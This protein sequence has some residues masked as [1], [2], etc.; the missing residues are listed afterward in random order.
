MRRVQWIVSA[1][2][3][4][5]LFL[6]NPAGAR[7]VS[8]EDAQF[9]AANFTVAPQSGPIPLTVH[10]TDTSTGLVDHWEWDFGDHTTGSVEKNPSHVYEKVG[11]YTVILRVSG[12]YG[13]DSINRAVFTSYPIDSSRVRWSAHEVTQLCN[14]AVDSDGTVYVA[15]YDKELKALL[16]GG[17]EKWR[18]RSD[19]P[20]SPGSVPAVGTDTVYID[21]RMHFFAV[22]KADGTLKWQ[23]EH[24]FNAAASANTGAAIGPDG[25]VYLNSG[26]YLYALNPDGS[27]KWARNG[28]VFSIPIVDAYGTVYVS[29][30]CYKFSAFGTDGLPI[31]SLNVSNPSTA[32]PAMTGRHIIIPTPDRL[33]AL[34]H[35]G[36]VAWKTTQ[37]NST[38]AVVGNGVIYCGRADA[39]TAV[40]PEDGTVKWTYLRDGDFT[41][42]IGSLSVGI[43]GTLY[44]VFQDNNKWMAVHAI[45]PDGTRRWIN[46]MKGT[47]KVSPVLADGALYLIADGGLV[48]MNVESTAVA[49]TDWPCLRGNIAHTG[50]LEASP[51]DAALGADA[52]SGKYP[53]TVHFSDISSGTVSDWLWS[54]GDGETS[55]D[56]NPIHTYS[57]TGTFPVSLQVS[58]PAGT[59]QVTEPGFITVTPGLAV[60]APAAG[61]TWNGGSTHNINWNSAGI[62][63]PV[64][65]E[66]LQGVSAKTLFES[67]PNT[68]RQSWIVS[69]VGGASKIRVSSINNSSL[70]A[71]SKTFHVQT[72]VGI[73]T[74]TRKT[75][76]KIGSSAQVQWAGVGLANKGVKIEISR[77]GGNS[78]KVLFANAPSTGEAQGTVAGPGTSNAKIRV[79]SIANDKLVAVTDRFAIM[80]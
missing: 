9:P 24:G 29:E 28:G 30:N 52:R 75:S 71:Q 77:D 61:E 35:D 37:I 19:S 59:D 54:F 27:I 33:V 44:A 15:G 12:P 49:K 18:F 14:P 56:Q 79:T 41:L 74:P 8:A 80:R 50:R 2:L 72:G 40:K 25:T 34:N 38:G 13:K 70:F 51:P 21:S 10:F 63:G 55:E 22:N 60:A 11:T 43:D 4:L 58:G 62:T 68:G 36:T 76:W 1:T 53:F 17:T 73:L 47:Y 7:E 67:V 69:G 66:L 65:I 20:F 23:W 42:V 64:K 45:N 57:K 31:W 39:I 6:V 3:I 46:Y 5:V 78:W 48:A 32:L 16:P 26:K